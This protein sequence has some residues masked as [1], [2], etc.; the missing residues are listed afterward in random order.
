MILNG[1]LALKGNMTKN[2]DENTYQYVII[3][4]FIVVKIA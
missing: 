2:A 3:G 1:N 4:L